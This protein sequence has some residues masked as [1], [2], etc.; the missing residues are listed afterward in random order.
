MFD[1]RKVTAV[2][3]ARERADIAR[4]VD[5]RVGRRVEQRRA[6]HAQVRSQRR[7]RH[8][9]SV[10]NNTHTNN[11]HIRGKD[12]TLG[13][14]NTGDNFVTDELSH[15]GATQEPHIVGTQQVR[16]RC[17]DLAAQNTLQRYG[18]LPQHSHLTPIT[19]ESGRHLHAHKRGPRHNHVRSAVQLVTS[20]SGQDLLCVVRSPHRKDIADLVPSDRQLLGGRPSRHQ[21]LVELHGLGPSSKSHLLGH[22]VQIRDRSVQHDL[23]VVLLI[24]FSRPHQQLIGGL[25]DVLG[26]HRALVRQVGLVR[27]QHNA[28]GEPLLAERLAGAHGG[29]S[30]ANDGES[31]GVLWIPLRHRGVLE[32]LQSTGQ[33]NRYLAVLHSDRVS[34]QCLQGRSTSGLPGAQI[35]SSVVPGTDDLKAVSHPGCKLPLRV[36]AVRAGSVEFTLQPCQQDLLLF[37]PDLHFI[38]LPILKIICV[39]HHHRLAGCN[40]G[41]RDARR[42]S[43]RDAT[44]EA[45]R[46]AGAIGHAAWFRARAARAAHGQSARG[47]A[48]GTQH[49]GAFSGTQKLGT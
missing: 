17:S 13:S 32:L 28:T 42:G 33:R 14:L 36:G 37:T 24:E 19:S 26:E 29:C 49:G 39:P 9:I 38:H 48:N 11:H 8:K 43:S 21:H 31:L 35:E 18:L 44:P 10:G 34:L 20:P 27:D 2:V 6:L 3:Q 1:A 25:Q 22:A 15:L 40:C 30:T 7:V 41:D 45:L 4:G 23:D 47:E 16:E 5:V 46:T 12:L